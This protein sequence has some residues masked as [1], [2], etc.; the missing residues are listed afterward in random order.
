[1]IRWD[2]EAVNAPL[3]ARYSLGLISLDKL[4]KELGV[5]TIEAM[6]LLHTAEYRSDYSFKDYVEGQK[7]LADFLDYQPP[8]PTKP[9]RATKGSRK[10]GTKG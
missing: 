9:G 7:L 6:Q 1:M 2:K 5:T 8:A 3:F 4:S 10:R